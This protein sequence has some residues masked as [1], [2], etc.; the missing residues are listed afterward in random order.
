MSTIPFIEAPI[1]K[2]FE[3][4]A[5]DTFYFAF[6]LLDETGT[7]LDLTDW[8]GWLEGKI[9]ES[10]AE[11]TISLRVGTGFT[12]G[13]AAGT[14]VAKAAPD[15]TREWPV[16][17]MGYRLKL[18]DQPGDIQTFFAGTIMVRAEVAV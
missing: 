16:Q 13:G 2:D 17:S 12:L 15:V 9:S 11:P 10:D 4:I 8:D 18:K 7:P 3:A 1:T 5:G 14:V 6:R